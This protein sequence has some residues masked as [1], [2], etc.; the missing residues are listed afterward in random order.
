MD[1]EQ[2]AASP[3]RYFRRPFARFAGLEEVFFFA[4]FFLA[5]LR[6]GLTADL[7]LDDERLPP[8]KM[9]SQLSEYCFVAP[10][11]TTLMAVQFP[12]RSL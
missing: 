8:E 12:L 5:E 2:F 9:L 4:A 7:A 1:T 3:G 10:T 11:R 6:A